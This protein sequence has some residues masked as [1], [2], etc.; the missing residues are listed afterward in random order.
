MIQNGVIDIIA[1]PA[2]SNEYKVSPAPNAWHGSDTF[3]FSGGNSKKELIDAL[4]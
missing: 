1:N 4:A 3:V 2:L